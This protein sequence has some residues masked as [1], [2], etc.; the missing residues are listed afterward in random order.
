MTGQIALSLVAGSP[1]VLRLMAGSI[2]AF[3]CAPS[4]S[5]DLSECREFVARL[6]LAEALANPTGT[7]RNYIR[8]LVRI[9]ANW[10]LFICNASFHI[11]T[12]TEINRRSRR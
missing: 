10:F 3:V 12:S 9:L 8:L 7:E 1:A 6:V 5:L 2:G 4:K 11:N